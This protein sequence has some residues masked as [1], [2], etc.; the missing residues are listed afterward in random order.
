MAQRADKGTDWLERRGITDPTILASMRAVPRDRFYEDGS[1]AA[2]S[3]LD[4]VTI[5]PVE[6]IAK[7]LE[8]LDVQPDFTV[9]QVGTGSGYASA[10]L[11]RMVQAVFTVERDADIGKAAQQRLG[12]LGYKNVQVLYGAN[13]KQYAAHAPYDAILVSAGMARLPQQLAKRLKIGGVLVAPVGQG[14]RQ[15][16][17]RLKRIDE[18]QFREETVGDLRVAPLLGD[19]LVE[20][21]VVDREDVELAAMEADAKGK[22]LGEALLDGSYVEESDIYA[23]LARQN[24]I[25]LRSA[26]EV[27]REL[28]RSRL[29]RFPKAFLTHN[30]IIPVH[31][32]DGLMHV[33]TTDPRTDANELAYAMN[34]HAVDLALITPSDY[35]VVLA[36]LEGGEDAAFDGGEDATPSFGAE[37]IAQFEQFMQHAIK[38]YCSA[39]HF[40]RYEDEVTVA[41]RIEGELHPRPDIAIGKAPFGA[42]MELVKVS[43]HLDRKERRRAQTGH[44]E[45]RFMERVFEIRVT[46]VPTALGESVTIHLAM[47]GA[48]APT[49]D[50]LGLVPDVLDALTSEAARRSGVIVIVGP[51][52]SG[53]STTAYAVLQEVAAQ[54][55]CKIVA[56]EDPVSYFLPDVQ[57]VRLDPEVFDAAAAV[58]AAIASSAD[59]V[60]IGELD[61]PALAAQAIRASRAGKLVIVT[62]SGH[63][64][65]DGITRL[66]ELGVPATAVQSEVVAVLAQRLAQRICP[67]CR[68]RTELDPHLVADVFG[69]STPKDLIAFT[70]TGCTHCDRTGTQGRLPLVELLRVGPE[71]Q[72]AIGANPTTQEL[73]AIADAN[74]IT[75]MLNNATRLVKSGVIPQHELRWIHSWS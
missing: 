52:G 73:R 17:V 66:I 60:L 74:G 14:R 34:M 42:M 41:Y 13:L 15:Q 4:G 69:F 51:E 38:S 68:E 11:S 9:L 62:M 48:E 36:G 33:V 72:A 20:M 67:D 56:V 70:G 10:V 53:R 35:N 43:A 8:T 19:I 59:V 6:V 25:P 57:H 39:I 65:T 50:K 32:R 18:D 16:L 27:L 5:T 30:R 23:A 1:D 58:D 75:T 29:T 28:D 71:I 49:L 31:D 21:G 12:E 44:F 24:D 26:Q 54:R 55:A 46:I 22:R 7:M 2:S 45:R 47:Q 3:K 61:E 37:T 40:E 63:S 64:A